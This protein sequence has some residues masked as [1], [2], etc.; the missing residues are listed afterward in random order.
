MLKK[1]IIIDRGGTGSQFLQGNTLS[2]I[3]GEGGIDATLTLNTNAP[4]DPAS[5]N[6]RID[7]SSLQTTI[8]TKQDTLNS[9]STISVD[10]ITANIY[11]YIYVF[12]FSKCRSCLRSSHW[13]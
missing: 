11:I 4:N 10:R 9:S 6:M 13:Y 1:I 12:R 2:R 8:S 3:Y 7:G 5:L